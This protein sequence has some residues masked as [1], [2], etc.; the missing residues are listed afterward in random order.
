M[1]QQQLIRDMF[2]D[3]H[4]FP[5]LGFSLMESEVLYHLTQGKNLYEIAAELRINFA[6]QI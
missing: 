4:V 1:N 2:S 3:P 6:Q 5:A